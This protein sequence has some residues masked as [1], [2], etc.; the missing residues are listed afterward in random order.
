MSP[1]LIADQ[2]EKGWVDFHPEDYCHQC[3]GPNI[4]WFSPEWVALYG[5]DGGILCPVCFAALDPAAIWTV[6][7]WTPT[8][9]SELAELADVLRGCTSLGDDAVRVA[10]C[11]LDARFTR[12]DLDGRVR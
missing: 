5:S 10:G 9:E 8:E 6:T 2:R 3:G 4:T 7:R 12:H 11:I 1:E